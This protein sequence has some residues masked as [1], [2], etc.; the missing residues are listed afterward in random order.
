M[1]TVGEREAG[2][3]WENSIEIYRAMYKIDR[4]KLLNNRELNLV[5]CD[6]LEGWDGVWKGGTRRRRYV[7]TL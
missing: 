6:I 5:L 3:S 1:D 7:Y 4:R 2:T